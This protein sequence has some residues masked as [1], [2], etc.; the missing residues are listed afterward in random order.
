[1]GEASRRRAL[2]ITAPKNIRNTT[3]KVNP[4][5]VETRRCLMAGAG[6]CSITFPTLGSENRFM[7]QEHWRHVPEE[8]RV[9][10]AEG[11][12]TFTGAYQAWQQTQHTAMFAVLEAIA[13]KD[14]KVAD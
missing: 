4:T 2:G 7:C 10:L 13:P 8:L 11:L 5:R 12:Q 3:P 14:S 1:M 6:R 9:K